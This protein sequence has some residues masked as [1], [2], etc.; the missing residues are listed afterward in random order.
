MSR[1][2]R[3]VVTWLH[4]VR[5]TLEETTLLFRAIGRVLIEVRH[6]A[7]EGAKILVEVGAIL[8]GSG[9]ALYILRAMNLLGGGQCA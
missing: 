9:V 6:T 4:D 2:G 7:R 1:R 3:R 5:L 8:A